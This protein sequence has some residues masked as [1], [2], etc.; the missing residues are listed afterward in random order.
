[1]TNNDIKFNTTLIHCGQDY[2]KVKID[3]KDYELPL[4]VAE[5]FLAD[6]VEISKNIDIE[7]LKR[8]LRD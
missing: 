5:I 8:Y 2:V 6:K 4:I 7:E 3:N 1:M